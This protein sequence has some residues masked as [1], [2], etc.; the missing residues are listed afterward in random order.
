MFADLLTN[1]GFELEEY[2]NTTLTFTITYTE[3]FTDFVY[4]SSAFFYDSTTELNEYYGV[5][6]VPV[7]PTPS[8]T[9]TPSTL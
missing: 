9:V 1:K 3:R 2:A 8:P 7:T 4:V 5:V 6:C